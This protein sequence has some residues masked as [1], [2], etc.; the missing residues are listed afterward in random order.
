MPSQP[1]KR[2]TN[3]EKRVLTWYDE[4]ARWQKVI[5]FL[6]GTGIFLWGAIDVDPGHW[7]EHG[8]GVA[9]AEVGLAAIRMVAGILVAG[10]PLGMWLIRKAPLPKF[11]K[12]DNDNT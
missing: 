6:V 4:L 11:L 7:A 8:L 3:G 2:P 5:L 1:P 9:T 12:R 10:P